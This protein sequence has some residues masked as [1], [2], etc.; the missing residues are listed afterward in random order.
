M[1]PQTKYNSKWII[2]AVT[3]L[4]TLSTFAFMLGAGF[5][6]N[7][8]AHATIR[9]D[10]QVTKEANAAETIR[11]LAT[12]KVTGVDISLI[13]TD[14]KVIQSTLASVDKTMERI[15]KKIP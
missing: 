2:G 5:K 14:I 7:N 3:F 6:D 9:A 4:I 1:S 8:A 13:K 12:D 11:S 10:L 15:E